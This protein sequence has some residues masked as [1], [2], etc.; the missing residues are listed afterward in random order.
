MVYAIEQERDDQILKIETA[1]ANSVE[2]T[3]A[4][5]AMDVKEIEKETEAWTHK[6]E[7]EAIQTIDQKKKQTEAYIK[8]LDSSS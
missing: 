1:T 4:S 6:I 8:Y 5:A 3:E 2:A 7:Y